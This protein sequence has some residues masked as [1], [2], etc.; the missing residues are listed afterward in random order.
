MWTFGHQRV[1]CSGLNSGPKKLS[2][3]PNLWYL[4]R[5]HGNRVCRVKELWEQ[6][7]LNLGWTLN[8][9]TSVLKREGEVWCTD[10]TLRSYVKMRQRTERRAYKPRSGRGCQQPAAAGGSKPGEGAWPC[11]AFSL[12]LWPQN[13]ERTHC[14]CFKLWSLL[15][16]CDTHPGNKC[17]GGGS[18]G[19]LYSAFLAF[20][21]GKIFIK[22][23][24]LNNIQ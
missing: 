22:I 4:Q 18:A 11:E 24:C 5:L 7:I 23:G 21:W 9:M 1:D 8:L 2:P 12:D 14:C 19:I 6:V 13:C 10:L 20:L 3:S 17:A 15:V 16:I